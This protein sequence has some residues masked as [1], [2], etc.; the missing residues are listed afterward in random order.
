MEK[1]LATL[2]SVSGHTFDT[3]YNLYFTTERMIAVIIQHP[4]D[5]PLQPASMWQITF[6]GSGFSKRRE[7]LDRMKISQDRY[8]SLQGLTPNELMAT[9]PMNIQ[10]HY[11]TIMSFQIKKHLF[12]QKLRFNISHPSGLEKIIDFALPRKKISEARQ[13]METILATNV[14][15]DQS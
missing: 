15:Q 13:I 9:H 4:S 8:E 2:G 7:R 6:F 10:I 3:R 1:V 5:V 14:K 11:S 12:Q